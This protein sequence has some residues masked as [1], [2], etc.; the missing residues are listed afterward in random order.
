MYIII[1]K[2]VIEIKVDLRSLWDELFALRQVSGCLVILLTHRKLC[3]WFGSAKPSLLL[4]PFHHQW[5]QSPIMGR[6]FISAMEEQWCVMWDCAQGLHYIFHVISYAH[7]LSL[8]WS[9]HVWNFEES[10]FEGNLRPHTSGAVARHGG[11]LL[12][13]LEHGLGNIYLLW[14]HLIISSVFLADT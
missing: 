13:P 6:K 11:Q 3:F 5:D 1:V 4:Q 9:L 8:S 10:N 14:E 7:F 2:N 12:Q